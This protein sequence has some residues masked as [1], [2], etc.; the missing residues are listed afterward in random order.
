MASHVDHTRWAPD[1][2]MFTFRLRQRRI[3]WEDT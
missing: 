3:R 2:A 1:D